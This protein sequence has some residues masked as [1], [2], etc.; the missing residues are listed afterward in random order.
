[1]AMKIRAVIMKPDHRNDIFFVAPKKLEGK[2]FT[3]AE[4]G[5]VINDDHFQLTT[6]RPWYFLWLFKRYHTTYYY[7]M[8]H[9]KP[10]PVPNFN[11]NGD[12]GDGA[13]YG[14]ELAAIFNPWFYRTIAAPVRDM[15]Q[16]IQFY[17]SVGTLLGVIYIAWTM[18]ESGQ[19]PTGESP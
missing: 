19:T 11:M 15:W 10:L 3:H 8:G 4:H 13:V 1:M 2:K 18:H 17:I 14:E 12:A 9:P 7:A 16:Q 6:D 5:Y